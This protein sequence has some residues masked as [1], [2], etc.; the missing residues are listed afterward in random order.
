MNTNT[1]EEVA[2]EDREFHGGFQNAEEWR[3]AQVAEDVAEEEAA[4]AAAF[5]A[6]CGSEEPE[7]DDYDPWMSPEDNRIERELSARQEELEALIDSE[8]PFEVLKEYVSIDY[9]IIAHAYACTQ[10]SDFDPYDTEE[11]A[12]G[13]LASNPNVSRRRYFEFLVWAHNERMIFKEFDDPGPSSNFMCR[14][15]VRENKHACTGW[16]YSP[17]KDALEEIPAWQEPEFCKQGLERYACETVAKRARE[18]AALAQKA[19]S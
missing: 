6:W 5:E 4:I 19:A 10:P 2:R 1:N 13:H 14:E 18:Q 15:C 8:T 7:P 16:R 17:E 9:S 12:H 3:A 11:C